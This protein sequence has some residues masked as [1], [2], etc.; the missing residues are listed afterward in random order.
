[1]AKTERMGRGFVIASPALSL[2]F[3]SKGS[4]FRTRGQKS[5]L[6]ALR[7]SP[8]SQSAILW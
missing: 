4:Q 6:N 7:D 2:G 5:R 1:M 3:S 8:L